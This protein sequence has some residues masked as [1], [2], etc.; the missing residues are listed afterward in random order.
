MVFLDGVGVLEIE[1]VVASLDLVDRDLPGDFVF[2]ALLPPVDAGL[3]VL[4]A[5]RLGHRVGLLAL[6]DA[7]LVVPDFLGRRALLEEEQVGADG[8]VG[9]EDAV[10]QADD[11]VEVALLQQVFLQP[12]LDA[13]AEQ[14]AVG[15]DHGGAAVGFEQAH[16]EGEEEVGGL[17][18]LE[19]FR[20]SCSRCRLPRARRRGDW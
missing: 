5:D 7:V 16:D 8:G 6:G 10:G 15:Q 20:E 3:Q 18:G 12:R 9:F 1:V 11:G 19:V 17:A 4:E 14:G 13:F 2:L